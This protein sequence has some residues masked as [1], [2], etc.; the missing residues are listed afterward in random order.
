MHVHVC[1][2]L[3]TMNIATCMLVCARYCVA[4][5]HFHLSH[6][7][8]AIIVINFWRVR[9]LQLFLFIESALVHG[10][11]FFPP[12]LS[13][14]AIITILYSHLCFHVENRQMFSMM[15]QCNQ[16]NGMGEEL[17]KLNIGVPSELVQFHFHDFMLKSICYAPKKHPIQLPTRGVCGSHESKY[18]FFLKKQLLI[19]N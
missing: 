17:L 2:C 18:A 3:G 19:K 4:F 14:F 16:W 6:S 11:Y 7:S 5:M 15:M 10:K 8:P 9:T 13:L 12:H 1:V